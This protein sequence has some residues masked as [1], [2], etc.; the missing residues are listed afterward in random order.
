ML[1]AL[2]SAFIGN[3]AVGRLAF[4]RDGRGVFGTGV[5]RQQ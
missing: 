5:Q 3:P 2:Y 4:R 1:V